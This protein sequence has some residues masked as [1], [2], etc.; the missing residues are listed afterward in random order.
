MRDSEQ[1]EHTVNS[2]R[3]FMNQLLDFYADYFDHIYRA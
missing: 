1:E 2:I 3:H